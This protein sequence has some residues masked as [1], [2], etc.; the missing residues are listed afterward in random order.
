MNYTV[1]KVLL[2]GAL[3]SEVLAANTSADNKTTSLLRKCP[4]TQCLTEAIAC[5]SEGSVNDEGS[6]GND[7]YVRTWPEALRKGYR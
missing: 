3:F 4:K 7:N 5:L 1:F 2:I 6:S